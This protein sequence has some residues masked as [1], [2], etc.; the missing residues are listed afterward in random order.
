M[1]KAPAGAFFIVMPAFSVGLST[2]FPRRREPHFDYKPRAIAANAH[3]K[4]GSR[5]RGNDVLRLTTKLQKAEA[6]EGALQEFGERTPGISWRR[7]LP[8]ASGVHRHCRQA[9]RFRTQAFLQRPSAFRA[10]LSVVAAPDP[11]PV[12]VV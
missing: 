7:L 9:N 5:L 3:A 2:S 12:F 4:L 8:V 10:T 11:V 6:P 1:T